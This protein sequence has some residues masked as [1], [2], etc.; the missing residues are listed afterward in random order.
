MAARVI[1]RKRMTV[2]W[3]LGH[4]QLSDAHNAQ[5]R[6]N[7]MRNDEVDGLAKLA[8]TLP[9]PLYTPTFPC[10]ISLGRTEAPTRPSGGSQHSARTRPVRRFSWVT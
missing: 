2:R 1:Q 6:T 4:L 5:R 7:I 10:S 3:I 9:P 8:T